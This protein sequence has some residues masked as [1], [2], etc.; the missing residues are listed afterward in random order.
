M[1]V[2]FY[3]D[4]KYFLQR[5]KIC[6]ELFTRIIVGAR[7]YLLSALIIS[8]NGEKIVQ[9]KEKFPIL[10]LCK[11]FFYS[12]KKYFLRREKIC[13]ELLTRIIVGARLYLL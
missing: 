1:Q 7:L 13:S 3:S 11:Y 12:D 10:L 8:E 2:F 5:E 6:S 4:K 9:Q